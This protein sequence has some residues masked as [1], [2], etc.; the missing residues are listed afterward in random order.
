MT[1]RADPPVAPVSR[2][3]GHPNTKC[4]KSCTMANGPS[5]MLD[6]RFKFIV[7]LVSPFTYGTCVSPSVRWFVREWCTACERCH[8]K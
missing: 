1:P 4:A 5:P 8:E 6:S 7:P 2:Y 3:A